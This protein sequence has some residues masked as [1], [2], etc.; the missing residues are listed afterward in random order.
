MANI[1]ELSLEEVLRQGM[2]EAHEQFFTDEAPLIAGYTLYLVE[3][4][5]GAEGQE[6]PKEFIDLRKKI[7]NYIQN[8]FPKKIE[9]AVENGDCLK[10]E[11]L[12]MSVAGHY[13]EKKQKLPL[14]LFDLREKIAAIDDDPL[15]AECYPRRCFED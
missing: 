6:L 14:G 7:E 11:M 9:L 8:E 15:F 5:Y 10:A 3:F 4:R 13:S 12:F 2:A 1:N